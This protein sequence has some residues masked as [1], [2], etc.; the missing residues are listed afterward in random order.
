M[1][2]HRDRASYT[3]VLNEHV[4]A[5]LEF[6]QSNIPASKLIGAAEKL[7]EMARLLWGHFPQEPVIPMAI[8]IYLG[9]ADAPQPDA[10]ESFPAN[11]GADGDSVVA[12]ACP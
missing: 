3:V 6:M 12:V 4:K 7:P 11:S 5:V 10:I 2:D 1:S 9:R 8:S